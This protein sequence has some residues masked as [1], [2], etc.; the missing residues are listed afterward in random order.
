MNVF[1]FTNDSLHEVSF[2]EHKEML[3]GQLL[4]HL[5]ATQDKYISSLYV[6]ILY[7]DISEKSRVSRLYNSLN[8]QPICNMSN[9]RLKHP[10][11]ENDKGPVKLIKRENGS[12]IFTIC[13][14]S[15]P[16]YHFKFAY[17]VLQMAVKEFFETHF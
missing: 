9:S 17:V 3:P 6:Y 15:V 10:K 8:S 7:L 1:M 14:K 11:S 16:L 4:Q 13:A 12:F 2:L 5:V